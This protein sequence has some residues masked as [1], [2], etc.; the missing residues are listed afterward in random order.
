MAELRASEE[1]LQTVFDQAAAGLA[2]TDISGTFVQVNARYCDIV[3]RSREEL[4]TINMQALTHADDIQANAAL[5]SALT[6]VGEAFD[7]ENR[8]LRPNGSTVWVRNLSTDSL[9]SD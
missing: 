6:R 8:C 4:L 3:G 7:I 2:L 9:R 1:R 5:L